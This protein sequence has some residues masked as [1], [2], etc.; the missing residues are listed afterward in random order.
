VVRA[1][2]LL[3]TLKLQN[4]KLNNS[5]GD[6]GGETIFVVVDVPASGKPV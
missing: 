6:Q 4:I 3:G 5:G 1:G 2:I